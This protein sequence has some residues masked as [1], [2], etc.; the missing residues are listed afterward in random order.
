MRSGTATFDLDLE[1][2]PFGAVAFD[3]LKEAEVAFTIRGLGSAN[4]H[5]DITAYLLVAAWAVEKLATFSAKVSYRTEGYFG[6]R[7][8]AAFESPQSGFG[9]ALEA[10]AL[11]WEACDDDP[12]Q[13]LWPRMEEIDDEIRQF[14]DTLSEQNVK[15]PELVDWYLADLVMGAN[16]EWRSEDPDYVRQQFIEFPERRFGYFR[17][18]Y[19]GV[20]GAPCYAANKGWLVS[21][22][23][24]LDTVFEA[25]GQKCKMAEFSP[26]V[27]V[28]AGGEA[29]LCAA[30]WKKDPLSGV[31]GA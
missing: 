16:H 8:V 30:A 25:I 13:E 12:P 4:S 1:M 21:A 26:A 24:E 10:V 3:N 5:L 28:L 9:Q 31:I 23:L 17:S 22:G 27:L 7:L 11:K 14:G 20:L 19:S 6:R 18:A 29:V 15:C 2:G